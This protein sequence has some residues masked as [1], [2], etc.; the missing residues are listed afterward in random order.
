VHVR[1]SAS[2]G[3]TSINIDFIEVYGEASASYLTCS[4]DSGGYRFGFGNQEKENDISGVEGGHLTYEYRIHDTRLGRFLSVDPL[5][6]EFPWNSSYAFAENDVIRCIDLE[7]KEKVEINGNVIKIFITYG[8]FKDY[9]GPVFD[10]VKYNDLINLGL[11]QGVNGTYFLDEDIEIIAD[12]GTTALL[13]KGEY[14]L[15][16]NITAK[17]YD[18]TFEEF[19]AWN[20]D[21]DNPSY[22]GSLGF[23]KAYYNNRYNADFSEESDDAVGLTKSWINN[24][25][26]IILFKS[27]EFKGLNSSDEKVKLRDEIKFINTA[28]HESL[29]H[30]MGIDHIKGEYK[31]GIGNHAFDDKIN[32]MTNEEFKGLFKPQKFLS[33][34]TEIE[35]IRIRSIEQ[36]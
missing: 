32:K 31:G 8:V 22:S 27:A 9:G 11:S 36:K 20:N 25:M 30:D 16:V 6:R 4:E 29:I 14:I 24:S 23:D 26:Q 7:G 2:F 13:N 33:N 21:S 35:A 15:D 1:N 17:Y 3:T 34:D 28:L 12:D 10:V 18:I 19:M 5:G